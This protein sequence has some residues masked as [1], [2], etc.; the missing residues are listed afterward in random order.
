MI[1]RCIQARLHRPNVDGPLVVLYI[2]SAKPEV[3]ASWSVNG[4]G[5]NPQ[6]KLLGKPLDEELGCRNRQLGLS[7]FV[8]LG[9][10]VVTVRLR[11]L[12]DNVEECVPACLI[13][14][15][16]LL[17]GFGVD[18][19]RVKLIMMGV[20]P[21][22]SEPRIKGPRCWNRHCGELDCRQQLLET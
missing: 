1:D 8:R 3:V 7:G 21:T 13:F 20:R 11:A 22:W 19:L 2:S 16:L 12:L 10:L 17:G 14:V 9:V 4:F 5:P 6:L 15:F 18:V